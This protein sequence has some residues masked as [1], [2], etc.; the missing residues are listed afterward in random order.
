LFADTPKGAEASA[1]VYSIVETAKANGLNVYTYL[2][3]LLLYMPDTEYQN[4]PEQL[5]LLMPWSEA[6][7]AECGK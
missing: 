4:H 2:E 3:Y 7:Q 6:V 5:E 1:A